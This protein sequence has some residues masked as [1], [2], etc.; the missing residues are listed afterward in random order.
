MDAVL[1]TASITRNYFPV[2]HRDL[3][4]LRNVLAPIPKPNVNISPDVAVPAS[5]RH[6]AVMTISVTELP[7]IRLNQCLPFL[8][9]YD[10]ENPN[11]NSDVKSPIAND[12]IMML[13]DY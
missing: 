6:E 9:R 1:D 8:L 4:I 7:N 13:L 12:S 11:V 3:D 10:V 5:S 2:P